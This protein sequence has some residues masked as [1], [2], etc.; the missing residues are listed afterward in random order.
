M[1][2]ILYMTISLLNEQMVWSIGIL[3]EKNNL[4]AIKHDNTK[5]IFMLISRMG[6]ISRTDI[7]K[8]LKLSKATVSI[9][10]DE[11]I[12]KDFIVDVGPV[13]ENGN[14]VGRKPNLLKVSLNKL[15]A[16]ISWENHFIIGTLIN[17][18]GKEVFKIETEITDKD[19]YVDK[20]VDIFYNEILK[21]VKPNQEIL[22]VC[23]IVPAI[24]D[25]ASKKMYSTVLP[26]KNIATSLLDLKKVISGYSVSIFN[27]TSCFAYREFRFNK[28][29][30]VVSL[31]NL[32]YGVGAVMLYGDSIFGSATGMS[33]QFGHLSI[34]RNGE[35]CDCGNKGCLENFVGEKALY[36][37]DVNK[38]FNN[39]EYATFKLLSQLAAQDDVK[40]I[41]LIKKLAGDM[42]FGISNMISLYNPEVIVIGGKGR[43]LG[44]T[45]LKELKS[46]LSK[47]G[48]STFINKI[49]LKYS[50]TN[51]SGKFTG[52]AFYYL[53]M[54]HNFIE[55][56]V[57][58]FYIG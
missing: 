6:T 34:D 25:K 58:G 4:Q 39:S 32:D 12:Q 8:Q 1:C 20:T 31:I 41:E 57:D 54:H 7:A 28:P 36:K 38:V 27:D 16:V 3:M 21:G 42:A 26:H 44:D 5:K 9:L 2:D 46:E 22:N 45:Y 49:Q 35:V 47:M 15:I 19:N 18:N 13:T 53:D 48:F 10:T 56:N 29:D 30:T 33:M 24:L 40:A 55:N 43:L 23:I 17:L 51:S 52:A 37:R 50:S 11:M 14:C